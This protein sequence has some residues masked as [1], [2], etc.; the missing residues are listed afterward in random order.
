MTTKGTD[1]FERLIATTQAVLQGTVHIKGTVISSP[2]YEI[3]TTDS[4]IIAMANC[5]LTIPYDTNYNKIWDVDDDRV[6]YV[7]SPTGS[8]LTINGT[9]FSGGF[10]YLTKENFI[11]LIDFGAGGSGGSITY[12]NLT[13]MP[14]AVGGY[15]AGT[16]FNNQT[17]QQMWDGLLYIY[18]NPSF[19]S[20][21]INAVPSNREVGAY[22]IG[23]TAANN[24][25]DFRWSTTHNSNIN[26]NSINIELVSPAHTYGSSL[27]NDGQE[28]ISD[29]DI[30]ETS[31]TNLT[32]RITGTNSHGSNFHRDTTYHF[33]YRYWA[34]SDS[35]THLDEAGIKAL[36][37][38]G[39]KSG[40]A[41]TYSLTGNGYKY[42]AFPQSWGTPN[43][44]KDADT[45]FAV[46][47]E[48]PYTLSIT[49]AYGITTNY[50]VYRTTNV[51]HAT[52][53]LEVS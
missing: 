35:N 53:N 34:G 3:K 8:N 16:T 29:N 33:L 32:F 41:G 30:Q 43:Q 13:P 15:P 24:S 18:Q 48:S 25:F 37:L 46:A 4:M 45:G 50:N 23:D 31:V 52:L 11:Q 7:F 20:F 44:F 1:Y 14:Q 38:T 2:S 12:T 36:P 39:L 19:S 6:I 28:T 26:A 49:N 42:I 21:Y 40:Y 22:L 5:D 17:M 9:S 47:M 10:V 51:I 27:A